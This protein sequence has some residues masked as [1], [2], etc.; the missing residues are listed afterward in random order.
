MRKLCHKV[1]SRTGQIK[2]TFD[3]HWQYFHSST[4]GSFKK[5]YYYKLYESR[6]QALPVFNT[7]QAALIG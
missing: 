5:K 1:L 3:E 4:D 7:V 6:H 2:H